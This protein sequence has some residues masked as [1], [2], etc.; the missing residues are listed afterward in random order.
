MGV[1][2]S[3]A[4][5]LPDGR[6]RAG[7]IHT[8]HGDIETP[9]F[10]PVGTAA[11]VKTVLP[12]LVADLGAHA[13]LANAYHLYLRPG[14]QLVAQAGGV[15][16]F[17]GWRGPTYTDSG[18]FQVLSLGAGHRKILAMDT[19][20]VGADQVIAKPE[21]RLAKVD[22][23]GVTFTS[24]VDGSKHR[25]TPEV[26]IAVQRDI[27]ADII[28]AFD[29]LTTLLHSE[30]YQRSS[31]ERTLRWARRC[32]AEH[33][34]TKG[35]ATATAA[36][37]SLWAVVQGAQY[38][39]LRRHCARELVG[40]SE[41]DEAEG[42]VGFGGFGI[43]GAIAKERLGEIIGWVAEELPE[44]KPRHVLGVGEPDDL[45][46]AVESGGDTFDCVAPT[47][48]ARN[49]VV[50]SWDGRYHL[51][52]AR[53]R[54]DFR[55][56]DDALANSSA[57]FTRAYIHHLFKIREPLAGTLASVHNLS[58]LVTLMARVRAAILENRYE[59][60]KAEVLGRYY[61]KR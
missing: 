20:G 52:N 5:R 59:E 22:E 34:R 60:Y 2:F 10:I 6:G 32:L 56:L 1:R 11:A 55:P 16:A 43:G 8:P 61:A 29:E 15:A 14:A 4:G 58:F 26:S 33:N 18:G 37:Q 36:P 19:A 9:A 38:E 49:G 13:V 7:V 46:A 27:G 44:H 23:D 39:Y 17:M 40:M 42:G 50:F 24:H 57:E 12:S 53:F 28:F 51:T 41:A 31:V 48:L 35:L 25:F 47:R 21:A 30:E 3:L 54:R 45:F